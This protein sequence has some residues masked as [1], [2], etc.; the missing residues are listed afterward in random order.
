MSIKALKAKALEHLVSGGKVLGVGRNEEPASGS[1]MGSISSKKLLRNELWSLISWKG[2]P[3]WFITLSPA[4]GRHPLCLYYAGSRVA[5]DD[6]ILPS[7]IRDQLVLSNPVA[8]A[9]F[10]DFIVRMF[11]KHVLGVGSHTSTGLYGKTS[12]YYGTVEQQGRLTLHL[13]MLIWICGSL[14]PGEIRNRLLSKDS[15]FQ[16][17]LIDYL[18]GCHQGELFQGPLE[19]IKEHLPA[20]PSGDSDGIHFVRKGKS[21]KALEGYEDPTLTRPVP[22]PRTLQPLHEPICNEGTLT[23]KRTLTPETYKFKGRLV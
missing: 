7:S 13:H 5:F 6:K 15:E 20:M 17:A 12:A 2:A 10:F 16:K 9:R 11:I 4:D 18:E 23:R 8:A 19:V 21:S 1:T 22:P 14:S 3:T